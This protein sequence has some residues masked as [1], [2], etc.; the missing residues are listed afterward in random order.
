MLNQPTPSSPAARP[1]VVGLFCDSDSRGGVYA[2]TR[3]LAAALVGQGAVVEVLTIAPGSATAEE[4]VRALGQAAS[5]VQCLPHRATST[6]RSR[7]I[8]ERIEAS[9]WQVFV[10]NYRHTTYAACARLGRR[11]SVKT[12]GVCHNDHESYYSLLSYYASTLDGL[13]GPS[14]KTC[15]ALANCLSQRAADVV[16]LP[17]GVDVPAGP[18]PVYSGGPL[19]LVYHGRLVEEQKCVSALVELAVALRQLGVPHELTLVGERSGGPDYAELARQRGVADSVRVRNSL[20]RRELFALLAE[21]HVAVLTSKYE[22][23]CLSLAEAQA[24]GLPAAAFASGGVIEEYLTDGENALLVPWGNTD[25]LARRIARWVAEPGLWQRMSD[26]AYQSAA[27]RFS[28]TAFGRRYYE[29]FRQLVGQ[30]RLVRWPRL[31]PVLAEPH[32]AG[33]ARMV[34]RAGSK[35][36]LWA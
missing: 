18:R 34:D 22:G 31:R 5:R 28:L 9:D 6:E 4:N 36:K 14:R 25:E 29:Y 26:S 30:R 12:V 11:S 8:F 1:L 17:H 2:Y 3:Q 21:Q 10:P 15:E 20:P 32:Q 7:Q 33:W 35:L 16:Y 24:V 27:D 23:F 13:V 19:R